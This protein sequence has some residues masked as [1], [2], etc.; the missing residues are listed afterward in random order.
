M[1]MPTVSDKMSITILNNNQISLV[2]FGPICI[3]EIFDKSFAKIYLYYFIL[4]LVHSMK[5]NFKI[6]PHYKSKIILES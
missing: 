3:K 5:T 6:I 1:A 4:L 2:H